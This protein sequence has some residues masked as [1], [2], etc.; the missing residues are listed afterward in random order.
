[1]DLELE[2]LMSV[3]TEH[4]DMVKVLETF[5]LVLNARRITYLVVAASAQD[6]DEVN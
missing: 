2:G 5:A 4:R 6:M 3:R 1:M